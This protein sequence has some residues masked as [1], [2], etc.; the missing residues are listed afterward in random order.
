MIKIE[1]DAAAEKHFAN[2]GRMF[3][4]EMYRAFGQ[5]GSIVLRRMK[6]QMADIGKGGVGVG[7]LAAQPKSWITEALHPG[8]P[9]GGVLAKPHTMQMFKVSDGVLTVGWLSS[10]DGWAKAFQSPESREFTTPERAMMHRRG[11]D[12]RKWG[13]TYVRPPRPVVAPIAEA[14]RPE[15][16]D[17]LNSAVRKLII[18]STRGGM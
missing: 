4:R 12:I 7:M 17:W 9:L 2:I 6:K 13:S 1:Y 5:V 15:Y 11:V 10:L 3:P 16:A 14:A 18:R 8:R